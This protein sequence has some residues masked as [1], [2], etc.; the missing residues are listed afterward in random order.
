LLRPLLALS[1]MIVL[2]SPS[3]GRAAP[4]DPGALANQALARFEAGDAVGGLKLY[5]QALAQA[6]GPQRVDILVNLGMAYGRL[7]RQAE[8]WGYLAWATRL[9]PA[10]AVE[11]RDAL[12]FL[13]EALAATHRRV[14]VESAP[15]GA[16]ATLTTR[17][18]EHT[19]ETPFD[20]WFGARAVEVV[21]AMDG[22]EPEQVSVHGGAA[23]DPLVMVALQPEATL[24]TTSSLTAPAAGRVA[25]PLRRGRGVPTWKWITLGAGGAVALAGAVTWGLASKEADDL[26]GRAWSSEA[27][28]DKAWD[29]QV[30]PLQMSSYALMGVGGAVA[31]TGGVLVLMD[32]LGGDG[33]ASAMT[34]TPMAADAGLGFCLSGRF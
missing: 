28:Y 21:I 30:V 23:A 1:L 11:V 18:Q 17:G 29:D 3:V 33:A 16:R 20:W 15:S 19:L 22:Y 25:P 9:H 4:P 27:A 13:E 6:V 14:R 26:G 31:L 12:T 2:L 24:A 5:H 7:D 10:R 32:A 34:L 8:A